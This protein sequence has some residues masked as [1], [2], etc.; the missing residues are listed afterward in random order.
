MKILLLAIGIVLMLFAIGFWYCYFLDWFFSL[1]A[2]ETAIDLLLDIPFPIT[3]GIIAF[4]MIGVIY[5]A[6]RF[7]K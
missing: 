7:G 6:L 3:L 2:I 5:L 4:I 1:P